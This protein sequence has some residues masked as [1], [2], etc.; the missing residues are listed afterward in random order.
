MNTSNNSSN[1]GTQPPPAQDSFPGGG[2]GGYG[3]S[4]GG[5]NNNRGNNNYQQQ[6]F[7]NNSMA[8]QQVPIHGMPGS[9]NPDML[10]GN[11][12]QRSYRGG[13][14]TGGSNS[15][16]VGGPAG[17]PFG[18]G[19]DPPISPTSHL[20]HHRMSLG[21][22]YPMSAGAGSVVSPGAN[23]GMG[24]P[25]DPLDLSGRSLG[26]VSQA[27]R[28]EE[29]LLNLLIARRQRGRLSGESS[30]QGRQS[31]Q[32]LADELV[33]L[34]QN[35][36]MAQQAGGG[37]GVG[38]MG[39]TGGGLPQIPGMPPLFDSASAGAVP[40]NLYPNAMSD[41]YGGSQRGNSMRHG[42]NEMSMMM[43]SERID[44]SPGRFQDARMA[45]M[46]M[47]GDFSERSMGGGYKRSAGG[48]MMGGPMGHMGGMHSGSN[49]MGGGYIDPSMMYG[50][51]MMNYPMPQ[52]SQQQQHHHHQQHT[53]IQSE[54][55]GMPLSKKKRTHK[56]KPADMPRRP[57]SAY[58]LFFSEER[59][60]ILKEI[61][62]KE[63]VGEKNEEQDNTIVEEDKPETEVETAESSNIKADDIESST[64][65]DEKPKAL[66]RPLIP[67]QKKR[68]PH[69]KTHGKI[70]FQ[71]LARMVGERW[72]ALPEDKR[73]YY[74]DLAEQDMKRQ[75][76]AM[77]DY[78]AK[79]NEAKMKQLSGDLHIE[80][81]SEQQQQSNH[82]LDEQPI[83]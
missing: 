69:R 14:D 5:T 30:K 74:K 19:A 21:A 43:M 29:L 65:T 10:M 18:M 22:F 49:L 42:N 34:R 13:G 70:S 17:M 83:A 16:G 3:P 8:Q 1:N 33:R 2:G 48:M 71:Q 12:S 54:E 20:A 56:K 75:K 24:G 68:R 28:E 6:V 62:E 61:E 52:L 4:R 37:P 53:Q 25:G 31:Q 82:A 46:S 55:L 81:K 38:R 47:R 64:A 51:Q 9:S 66:L 32:S 60:R 77:E 11:Q 36:A 80:F 79:Q 50:S 63:G 67:S 57:L 59:E 44:R 72:K 76:L 39:G 45:D 7:G 40:P 78:Y 26:N 23:F 35:R 73:Q 41:A 15:P 27:D 58:N